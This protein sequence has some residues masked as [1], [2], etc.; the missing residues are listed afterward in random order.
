MDTPQVITTQPHATGEDKAL[1]ILCHVS[2]LIGVGFVLPLIVYLIKKQEAGRA[3]AHAK[4]VLNF[5]L[6]VLLYLVCAMPLF[7]VVVGF[8]LVPLIVVG[9]L[10]LGVMAAIKASD[11]GFYRYP[12][13]IRFIS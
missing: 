8:V 3:A 9:S 7:I 11:G 12:L 1:I 5:H 13:T 10:V 6:S 2:A 4:E